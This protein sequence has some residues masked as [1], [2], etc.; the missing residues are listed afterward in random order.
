MLRDVKI[1][2]YD[3][4]NLQ[5]QTKVISTLRLVQITILTEQGYNVTGKQYSQF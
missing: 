5:L 3:V 2:L 1:I 4:L